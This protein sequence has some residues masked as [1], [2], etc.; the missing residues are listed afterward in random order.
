MPRAILCDFGL[1]GKWE[2]QSIELA[3]ENPIWTAPEVLKKEDCTTKSDVYS[4]GVILWELLTREDFMSNF[5]FM[6]E[7]ADAVISGDRP[8]IPEV[9]E[10][11]QPYTILIEKCWDQEPARRPASCNIVAILSSMMK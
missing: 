9:P 11:Y 3:V 1:S 2:S 5:R 6:G 10:E 8:K 7:I 4:M